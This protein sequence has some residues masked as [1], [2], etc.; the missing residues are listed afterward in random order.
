MAVI[1]AKTLPRKVAIRLLWTGPPVGFPLTACS[2]FTV[3]KRME[4][5]TPWNTRKP[6]V[7]QI[8]GRSLTPSLS[9]SERERVPDRA[10]EVC[11]FR[12]GEGLFHSR[13]Y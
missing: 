7:R 1:G 3:G 2:L 9:R 11:P 4:P 8:A 10:G 6:L 13:L 12:A 5:E